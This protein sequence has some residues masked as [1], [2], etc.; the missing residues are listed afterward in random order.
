MSDRSRVWNIPSEESAGKMPARQPARRR[1]YL[2]APGSCDLVQLFD[3][4]LFCDGRLRHFG[5]V[6]HTLARL[7]AEASGFD[8]LDQDRTGA[9]LFAQGFMQIFEDVEARI[10]ADQVH[11]LEWSHGV[12]QPQLQ[13]LVNIGG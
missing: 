5:I 2:S 11:E 6:V 8:V 4:A 1:R 13:G 9:K 12:V 7:A 3:C 10:E